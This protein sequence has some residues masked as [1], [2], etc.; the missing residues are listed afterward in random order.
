LS[1][2]CNSGSALA[3]TAGN[4]T[5]VDAADFFGRVRTVVVFVAPPL[6]G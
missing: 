4:V 2:R 5:A 1:S 6:P 3:G